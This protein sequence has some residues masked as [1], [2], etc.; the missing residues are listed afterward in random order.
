MSVSGD[1]ACSIASMLAPRTAALDAGI[2]STARSFAIELGDVALLTVQALS[3][4]THCPPTVM[5]RVV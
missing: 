2:S 3:R 1:S 4:Y 5:V